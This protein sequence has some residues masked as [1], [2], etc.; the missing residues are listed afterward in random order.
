VKRSAGL[1]VLL[2][3]SVVALVAV[4]GVTRP[5]PIEPGATPE[6]TAAAPPAPTDAGSLD[7]LLDAIHLEHGIKS[8]R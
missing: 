2:L 3:L 4:I 7:S 8:G 1:V 6:H 5:I